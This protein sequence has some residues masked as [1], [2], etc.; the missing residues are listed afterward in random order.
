MI[1]P[2]LRRQIYLQQFADGEAKIAA[3]AIADMAEDLRG[4]VI[5]G[6]ATVVEMSQLA[7]LETEIDLTIGAAVSGI[8]DRMNNTISDLFADEVNVI[9]GA[10]DDLATVSVTAP[11]VEQAMATATNAQMVLVSGKVVRTHTIESMLQEFDESTTRDV[12]HIIRAGVIT[13]T[14]TQD[15]AEQVSALVGSRTA[16]QAETVVRTGIAHIASTARAAVYAEN[17]D[18]LDGEEWV[19]TLDSRTRVEH[20]ALDGKIFPLGEGPMTPYG[21]NCRCVR[22][23]VIKAGLLPDM[24]PA[25]RASIDG[26]VSGT[27]TYNDWL[28]RQPS[29]F[30]DDVLGVERA[31]LFRGGGLTL[32]KFINDQGILLTLD[33]LKG[34]S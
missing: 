30:Q 10:M 2:I 34:K 13:G 6:T 19:A 27:T 11:T 16:W 23:P 33:E 1:D 4:V 14:P 22:I 8:T 24:P 29:S 15:L 9:A 7:A 20:A 25:D 31:E 21:W 26:P 32:D 3:E 12:I 18:I 17:A 28:K 5:A